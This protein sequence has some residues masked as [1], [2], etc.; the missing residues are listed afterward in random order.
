MKSKRPPSKAEKSKAWLVA[1]VIEPLLLTSTS[2][3]PP[4]AFVSSITNALLVKADM[5]PLLTTA[6]S[7]F[8]AAELLPISSRSIAPSLS[9]KEDGE[10]LLL[11]VRV[12]IIE[13]I[14]KSR[15]RYAVPDRSIES[16][17]PVLVKKIPSVISVA[18]SSETLAELAMVIFSAAAKS[19]IS[20]APDKLKLE[21]LTP[22]N[23]IVPIVA[24]TYPTVLSSL[25]PTVADDVT[26][27]S[28]A[29]SK[30]ISS[31]C[32]ARF[33]TA[34]LIALAPPKLSNPST[35]TLSFNV[36]IMFDW[37]TWAA[38]LPLT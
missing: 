22:A 7:T 10:V 19:M 33:S 26:V 5:V 16:T 28:D 30:S 1:A 6:I 38:M 14:F 37:P 32:P 27:K 2:I 25:S 15:S 8:S 36:K 9:I 11:V 13:P 24:D 35:S 23:P 34:S 31:I 20:M 21:S 17:S 4:A 3:S 29:P 18:S 12:P